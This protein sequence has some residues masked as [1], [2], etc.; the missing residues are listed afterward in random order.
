MF[1]VASLC[2]CRIVFGSANQAN[3]VA[4]FAL[5]HRMVLGE[6]L[7]MLPLFRSKNPMAA[8]KWT[9]AVEGG[10]DGGPDEFGPVG[11]PLERFPKS[12]VYLEGDNFLFW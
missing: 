3:G 6:L 5:L 4:V 1:V 9:G 11:D 2:P 7:P 10:Q 12:L 8:T